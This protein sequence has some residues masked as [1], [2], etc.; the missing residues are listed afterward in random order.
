MS[1]LSY[2]RISHSTV[3]S[4]STVRLSHLRSS[5]QLTRNASY[6]VSHGTLVPFFE[7]MLTRRRFFQVRSTKIGSQNSKLVQVRNSVGYT[8]PHHFGGKGT[9]VKPSES[10]LYRLSCSVCE[11]LP[12]PGSCGRL[13]KPFGMF[14]KLPPVAPRFSR[15]LQMPTTSSNLVLPQVPWDVC[16]TRYLSRAFEAML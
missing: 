12:V 9:S 1:D 11:L 5:K 13:I 15:P 6:H 3:A 10:D 14:T 4:I 2:L 16:R 8:S 7:Q